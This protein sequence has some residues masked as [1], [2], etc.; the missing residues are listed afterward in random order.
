VPRIVWQGF[1][2]ETQ[3][4][5]Y[6]GR[7][8][9]YLNEIADDGFDVGFSGIDPPDYHVHRLTE[10]RCSVQAAAGAIRAE[11]D[12]A[13]AIIL[14]HFQDAG[15]REVRSAVRIPV[16]GLGEASLLQ[17]CQ[18]GYRF[19]LITIHPNFVEWHEEQVRGY[20]LERRCAGV[21]ALDVGV[22]PFMQAFAGDGGAHGEIERQFEQLAR[23]LVRAGAEVI[24]PAGGL[25][26]LLLAT[27]AGYEIDGAVVLNVNG[28][29]VKLAEAA[30][31]MAALGIG[32]SRRGTY[33]LPSPE[34]LA[35]FEERAALLDA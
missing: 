8:L 23:E 3:N 31:R 28:V 16:L 33:R 14:G 7:L 34:A 11:R 27:R 4:A 21:R 32:P 5:A 12:G 19:G 25:P 6:V 24:V 2:S 18:L 35:E 10:L 15:L 20:A 22:E 17:A 26:S 29:I 13:D 9:E 1:T 30:V